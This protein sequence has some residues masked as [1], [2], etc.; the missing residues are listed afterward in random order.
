MIA[1]WL[2][3]VK[4]P[5]PLLCL[6]LIVRM[7][8][9]SPKREADDVISQTGYALLPF[10]GRDSFSWLAISCERIPRGRI[11]VDFT[12]NLRQIAGKLAADRRGEDGGEK[13]ADV[14]VCV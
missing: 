10:A 13:G 14:R 2:L 9:I 5:N 3:R 8:S 11:D 12:N 7:K 4:I 1:A 6:V